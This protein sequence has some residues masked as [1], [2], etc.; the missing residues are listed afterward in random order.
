MRIKQNRPINAYL[1]ALMIPILFC[2][3]IQTAPLRVVAQSGLI[4]QIS[5]DTTWTNADSPYYLTGPL[6]VNQ[7]VTLT[8]ESGF[9]VNLN[10]YELC[11]NGTLCAVGT[12]SNKIVFVNGTIIFTAFST[13][14][15]EETGTGSIIQFARLDDVQIVDN[16]PVNINENPITNN[17]VWT[18][19]D[20]P[21]EF[22]E[23]VVIGEGQVLT[24]EAGVTV[25]TKGYDLIVEGTLRVHGTESDKVYFKRDKYMGSPVI[26]FTATSNGWNEQ[27][28][29]GSIIDYAKTDKVPVV[30]STSIKISNSN[31]PTYVYVEGSSMLVGNTISYL[32]IK[33]GSVVC[34]NNIIDRIDA[35]YGSPQ[36][37]NNT[38]DLIVGSGGSPMISG[39]NITKFGRVLLDDPYSKAFSG[40]LSPKTVPVDWVNVDSA[41]ITNN[42]IAQGVYLNSS[43]AIVSYNTIK[44][45]T[46]KYLY[47]AGLVSSGFL[48]YTDYITTSGIT[49]TGQGYIEGNTIFGCNIGIDGGTTIVGNFLINN[50]CGVTVNSSAII[51][52][53]TFNA[54]EVAIQSESSSI[55]EIIDNLIENN[56][57][58]IIS[59]NS[60]TA[61]RNL[62][63][64]NDTG[65]KVS[66]DS[67]TIIQNNTYTGNRVAIELNQSSL[68]TISYNNIENNTQNSI[69]LV[70][71]SG[72]VEAT[73]NWWGTADAQAINLTI[74]DYKY[75]FGL[76]KVNFTPFL[77]EPNPEAKPYENPENPISS[78]PEFS[79][80]LL[81]PSFLAISF[82]VVSFRKKF[83]GHFR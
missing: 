35:C 40:K 1:N 22:T 34:S 10:G 18:K 53:N 2:G 43:L 32:S 82:A 50:T 78:I 65:T 20:S 67:Y 83:G 11:V 57:V 41:T 77:I 3:I 19:Q 23:N 74:H 63:K 16:V 42:T 17:S 72:T 44:S 27:T 49:L 21:I 25:D 48:T 59:S 6:L 29:T 30:S 56:T 31:I 14:W 61:Q 15:D 54:N 68:T 45:H 62:I 66:H 75:E 80:W 7:G 55:V 47:H 58:G 52:G 28:G 51:Q 33:G 26:N 39:N 8:I 79:S 71:I 46:Y 24:I 73:N 37:S 13:P 64:N 81:L 36:I 38:I 12:S 5:S 76:G 4:V 60:S 70:D 69:F 9:T